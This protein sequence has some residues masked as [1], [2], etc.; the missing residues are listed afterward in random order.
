[1]NPGGPILE[2]GYTDDYVRCECLTCGTVFKA[3]LGIPAICPKCAGI[4]GIP[5]RIV[6]R[7]RRIIDRINE[8]DSLY[9]KDY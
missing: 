5:V 2:L 3:P 8:L 9:Y 6:A 4:A 7:I 1:M